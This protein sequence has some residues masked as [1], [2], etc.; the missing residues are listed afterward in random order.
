M[1]ASL[2]K[3]Y[4]RAF[5]YFVYLPLIF[6]AGGHTVFGQI[7][8]DKEL[9][10]ILFVGD[11]ITD[12]YGVER[13]KA[14][15]TLVESRLNDWMRKKSQSAGL[16]KVYN[17]AVSGA[18]ATGGLSQLRWQLKNKPQIIVITLGGN[19]GRQATPAKEIKET[20]RKLVREAKKTQATIVLGGMKMFRNLGPEYVE[21][22]ES[23]YPT[24]A[25]EESIEL[26]PFILE[27]VGGIPEMN[28]YDGFHPNEKGHKKIAE[29]VAEFLKPLIERTTAIERT[30]Q[31]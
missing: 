14:F 25:R 11:S 23:I 24:L 30:K 31:K 9:V 16:V 2:T 15:P 17:A 8:K 4:L 12:G 3:T 20:I 26:I 21:Q 5:I 6:F 10:R 28:L 13:S 29:T 22:F 18:L 1:E 19:D 7:L 27:G